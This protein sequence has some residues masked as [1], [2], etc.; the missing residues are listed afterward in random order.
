MH[1]MV[2]EEKCSAADK[3]EETLLLIFGDFHITAD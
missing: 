1:S 3:I 2:Y